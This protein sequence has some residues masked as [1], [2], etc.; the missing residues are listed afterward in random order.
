MQMKRILGILLALCFL[1]SVTAAAVGA[2]EFRQVN[3]K[4]NDFK[5]FEDRQENSFK[6]ESNFG[7]NEYRFKEHGK[8]KHYH[9]SHWE[10]KRMGHREYR[11]NRYV[12]IYVIKQ[13][14]VPACW[15][16]D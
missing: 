12:V 7:N 10:N 16:Y 11:D 5:K 4:D 15:T 14:Y 1:M 2:T 9:P 8:N 13:V 6:K 3:K